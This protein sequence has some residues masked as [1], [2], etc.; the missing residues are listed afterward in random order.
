MITH[1]QPPTSSSAAFLDLTGWR[2][3]GFFGSSEIS[4]E[5][6]GEVGSDLPSGEWRENERTEMWMTVGEDEVRLAGRLFARISIDH[7]A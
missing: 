2:C 6:V 4:T 5:Y 1:L 7:S 3:D